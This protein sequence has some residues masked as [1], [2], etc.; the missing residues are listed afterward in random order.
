M[1][2]IG[3]AAIIDVTFY[4]SKISTTATVIDILKDG[5]VKKPFIIEVSYYNNKK[6]IL[7]KILVDADFG[8]KLYKGKLEKVYYSSILN[9]VTF[10]VDFKP[11]KLINI[12]LEISG[13]FICSFVIFRVCKRFR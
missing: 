7:D 1:L 2:L 11:P 10:F 5:T 3:Y 12:F 4:F 9:K 8:N 13:C 6:N